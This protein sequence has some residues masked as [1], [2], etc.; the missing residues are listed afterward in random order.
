MLSVRFSC[1]FAQR[2]GSNVIVRQGS[3]GIV[4]G[5]CDDG[6]HLTV[7]FDEREDGSDLCVNVTWMIHAF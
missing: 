3:P 2:Y 6:V 4:V 1:N 7:K 5:S